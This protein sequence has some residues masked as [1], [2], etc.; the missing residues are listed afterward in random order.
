MVLCADCHQRHHG[1]SFGDRD[2]YESRDYAVNRSRKTTII[3]SAIAEGKKVRIRYRTQ[4]Y[5]TKVVQTK[6]RV[7]TPISVYEEGRRIYFKGNCHLRNVERNFRV[8]RI[9][10]IEL[11]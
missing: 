10:N 5:H 2:E 1:Y 6:I 9:T 8:S 3:N 11:V 7:V 4:D